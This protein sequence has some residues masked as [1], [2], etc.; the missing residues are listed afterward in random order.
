MS[1]ILGIDT[2]KISDHM[3]EVAESTGVLNAAA[4]GTD[5]GIEAL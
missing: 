1:A 2:S 4:T 5:E 3:V